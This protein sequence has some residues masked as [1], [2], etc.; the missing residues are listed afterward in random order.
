MAV[1]TAT[2][3]TEAV[4]MAIPRKLVTELLELPDEDRGTL[5]A[6]LWRSLEPDDGNEVTGKE[7]EAVWAAEIDRRMREVA[8]GKVELVD[9]DLVDAEIRAMVD[10][11]MP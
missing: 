10:A 3:Y 6:L 7:W 2:A 5:A 11:P 1:T 9:G 4:A 8:E